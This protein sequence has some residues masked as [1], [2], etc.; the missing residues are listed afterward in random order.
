VFDVGQIEVLR[1]PQGTTRGI[2]APSGAITLT[3]RKPHL[4]ALGGYAS[5]T[6]DDQ[7]GRN[8]STSSRS[9][10]PPWSTITTS[11]A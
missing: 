8:A 6:A 10:S 3:A 2:A 9:A 4:S 11:G 7:H 1:G 5:L